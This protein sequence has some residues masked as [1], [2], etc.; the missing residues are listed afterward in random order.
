MQLIRYWLNECMQR[1]V[2]C[3]IPTTSV[4]PKRVIEI[5]KERLRLMETNGQVQA[6]YVVLSHCWGRAGWTRT[7]RTNL[8]SLKQ[9]IPWTAL[10]KTF[11]DAILVTQELGFQYIWIDGLCIVQDDRSDWEYHVST[12]A[13]IFSNAQIC[14]AASKAESGQEGCFSR[15][16]DKLVELGGP[17][18]RQL[19]NKLLWNPYYLDGRDRNGQ[20]K[21]FVAQ[22]KTPHGLYNGMTPS[23]PLLRRAWVFQEQILSP[24]II[25]FASGELYFECKHHVACECRGWQSRSNTPQWETR[26]R[27]AYEFLIQKPVRK[28]ITQEERSASSRQQFEAYR[29]LIE[30]FTE[31]DITAELD[32]LPAL[33]GV[34]SGRQ[35]QYLAGMWQGILLESLHWTALPYGSKFMARRPSQYRAPTWSWASIES[36]I[37]HVETDFYKTEHSPKM[38]AKII[39]VQCTPAGRDPRGCVSGGYL[40]IEGPTLEVEVV[41]MGLRSREMDNT[42]QNT[43]TERELERMVAA[44]MRT[45]QGYN[46]C[47]YAVLSNGSMRDYCYLDV[48]L[49]LCS[50]IPAEVFVGMKVTCLVLSSRTVLVLTS[51]R[52]SPNTYTR[53]GI[54]LPGSEGWKFDITGRSIVIK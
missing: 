54:F 35:D 18:P 17:T 13:D 50:S 7:T 44:G 2:E 26:W 30:R 28:Y 37:R 53:V 14:I 19:R 3:C 51:V 20:P 15:H 6:P 27:K 12:M 1:H 45:R 16:T 33:S 9:E 49:T 21:K 8:A 31:L 52:G 38:M 46:F 24:R 5:S 29:A 42:T 34:F 36:P 4:L 40:R 32:R 48:P 39:E 43:M 41:E 25:H 47:T 10:S 11:Q 23:E 22:L